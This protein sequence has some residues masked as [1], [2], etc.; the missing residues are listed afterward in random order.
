MPIP[1][2]L[3]YPPPNDDTPQ[4]YPGTVFSYIECF[5][6]T[7]ILNLTVSQ[8]MVRALCWLRCVRQTF[9]NT[10]HLH[11]NTAMVKGVDTP[12]ACFA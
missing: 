5:D 1:V 7:P 3:Y 4:T 10:N 9:S 11:K 6:G 2:P 12:F 8:L